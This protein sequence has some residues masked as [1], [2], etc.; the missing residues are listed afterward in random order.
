MNIVFNDKVLNYCFLSQVA[1]DESDKIRIYEVIVNEDG[2]SKCSLYRISP[3]D[4]RILY[5]ENK[6]KSLIKFDFKFEGSFLKCENIFKIKMSESMI[7][8]RQ[9]TSSTFEANIVSIYNLFFDVA[10]SNGVFIDNSIEDTCKGEYKGLGITEFSNIKV[11]KS[12]MTVYFSIKLAQGWVSRKIIYMEDKSLKTQ[13]FIFGVPKESADLMKR[14]DLVFV[15]DCIINNIM[16]SI[17]KYTGDISIFAHTS[18]ALKVFAPII[19]RYTYNSECYKAILDIC[20][21]LVKTILS[22]ANDVDEKED[23]EPRYPQGVTD[24]TGVTFILSG[25]APNDSRKMDIIKYI[26]NELYPK[27]AS[28]EVSANQVYG[29]L[30][31]KGLTQIEIYTAYTI[32]EIYLGSGNIPLD[33]IEYIRKLQDLYKYKKLF[34]DMYLYSIRAGLYISK[35]FCNELYVQNILKGSDVPYY[36]TVKRTN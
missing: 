22:F 27:I 33:R 6:D 20:N 10:K 15:R 11:S 36:A 12:T 26:T 35:V 16:Y 9:N 7:E 2:T 31:G 25:K 28:K 24:K 21:V 5:E 1:I 23:N 3:E 18:D 4:M 19:V 8:S 13:S 17:F 14:Y 30:L 32:L 29:I 34:A